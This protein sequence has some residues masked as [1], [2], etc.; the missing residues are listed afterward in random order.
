MSFQKKK[1]MKFKSDYSNTKVKARHL[2]TNVAYRCFKQSDF[3]K[4]L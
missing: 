3:L 2:L 1:K 4:V